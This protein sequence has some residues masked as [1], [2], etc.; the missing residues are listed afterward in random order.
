MEWGTSPS[1]NWDHLGIGKVDNKHRIKIPQDVYN[2]MIIHRRDEFDE[3]TDIGKAHWSYD[4]A[5][6][7][8]ILSDRPLS[9]DE[10]VQEGKLVDGNVVTVRYKSAND[11]KPLKGDND[12]KVN[13]PAKFFADTGDTTHSQANTL[14]AEVQFD[15]PEPRHFVTADEFLDET[16][17]EHSPSPAKS[18]YVLRQD[19][20]NRLLR[21]AIDDGPES[22]TPAEVPHLFNQL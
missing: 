10:T 15:P 21:Y 9:E 8:V 4:S 22:P 16:K 1:I 7:W 6:G 13:V 18:C 17:P 20:V 5:T 11:T 2:K 3:S 12:W 19:Q 14:P